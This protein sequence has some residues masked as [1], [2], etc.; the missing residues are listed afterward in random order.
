MKTRTALRLPGYDYAR[1]G[2]YFVTICLRGRKPLLG[3]VEG[4]TVRPGRLGEIVATEIHALENRFANVAVD[5][6]VV[7]PDHAHLILAD[8]K[9]VV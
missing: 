8:R 7:M 4:D 2:M 5:V 1:P 3:Q 6:S 9:S